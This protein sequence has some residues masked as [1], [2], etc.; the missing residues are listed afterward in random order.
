VLKTLGDFPLL[1]ITFVKH[2]N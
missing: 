1:W 2:N